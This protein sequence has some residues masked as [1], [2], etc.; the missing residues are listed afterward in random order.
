MLEKQMK[1]RPDCPKC[2]TSKTVE[3]TKMISSGIDAEGNLKSYLKSVHRCRK[4]GT[5]IETDSEK[6]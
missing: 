3:L 2:G 5:V 6:N 4:C 1:P